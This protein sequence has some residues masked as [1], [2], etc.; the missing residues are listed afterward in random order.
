MHPATLNH[1]EHTGLKLDDDYE[2]TAKSH[3][4]L[5]LET[6]GFELLNAVESEM[7]KAIR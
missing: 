5:P 6:Q 7:L 3:S 1:E 2:F 4:L